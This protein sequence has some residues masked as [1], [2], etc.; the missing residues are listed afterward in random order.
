M[1]N[2]WVISD[3]IK[4]FAELLGWEEDLDLLMNGQSLPSSPAEETTPK[5]D[6]P[7]SSQ[8]EKETTEK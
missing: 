1:S 6:E 8:K 3:G 5:A 2:I 7:E 4:K